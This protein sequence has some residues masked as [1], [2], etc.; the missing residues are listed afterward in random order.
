MDIQPLFASVL[1][2]TELDLDREPIID[3]AY[4]LKEQG[5]GVCVSNEGGWQSSLVT[6]E[7]EMAPVIAQLT[8]LLNELYLDL[9]FKSEYQQT[10]RDIWININGAGDYNKPHTH[11]GAFFSGVYYLQAEE[12]AGALEL[13]NPVTEHRYTIPHGLADQANHWTEGVKWVVPKPGLVAI[14]SPWLLHYVQP[15][16][17]G[18]DRISVAFNSYVGIR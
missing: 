5:P 18:H 10:I 7:P 4:R 13:V 14:F 12:W 1:A 11:P 15:N 2:Q 3:L 8:G 9:G 16:H 6:Q 17:S